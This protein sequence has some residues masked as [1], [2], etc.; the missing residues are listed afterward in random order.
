MCVMVN[1]G[2]PKA[3]EADTGELLQACWL[4]TLSYLMSSRVMLAT[5]NGHTSSLYHMTPR[6]RGKCS[7]S[8]K[9]S[10]QGSLSMWIFQ[11][12]KKA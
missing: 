5:K 3:G 7:S 6:Q 8:G 4:P 12:P 1:A 10:T 11:A 9:T 2:N